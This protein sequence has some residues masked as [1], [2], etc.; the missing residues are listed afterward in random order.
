[1]INFFNKKK[2]NINSLTIPNLNWTK[3]QDNKTIKQWVNPEQSIALSLHFFDLE[4]DLP[5]IK[6][7]DALRDFYRNQIVQHNGGLVLVDTTQLKT[8]SAVKTIFKIPQEP[9]GMVYLASL[10][11]PFK[12]CSYVVKI[13]AP[14][15]GMTGMRDTV[16]VDKLLGEG[17][18]SFGDDG[19]ENWFSDPYDSS[20][21]EGTLMNK[22]E[23]AIYDVDFQN[24]PLTLARQLIAQLEENIGFKPEI[25]KLIPFGK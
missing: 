12:T 13:Q 1:M 7:K 9:T 5:T 10:T 16:I 2:A 21:T 22:S 24:H 25:E 3:Q 15:I 23:D 20:F 19:I 14:E 11:I 8:H 4:P 6:N 17:K 18:I